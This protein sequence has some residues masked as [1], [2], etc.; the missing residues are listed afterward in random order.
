MGV[1]G[2]NSGVQNKES[3]LI[4]VKVNAVI[5]IHLKHEEPVREG[6]PLSYEPL[7]FSEAP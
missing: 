1:S 3:I 7:G 5:N 2:P 4:M 6:H